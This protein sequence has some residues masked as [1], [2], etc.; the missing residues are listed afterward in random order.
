MS[1]TF[2]DRVIDEG[3]TYDENSP[4]KIEVTVSIGEFPD[5]ETELSI[6][7][8]S[9]FTMIGLDFTAAHRLMLALQD[10]L[11][12]HTAQTEG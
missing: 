6:T 1:A 9:E 4:A 3:V 5:G 7:T 11:N 2:M 10:A 8:G 12:I